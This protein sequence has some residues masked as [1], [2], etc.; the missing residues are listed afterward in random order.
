MQRRLWAF[1]VLV[2]LAASMPA[3][4]AEDEWDD[5][6]GRGMT[7]LK[8][9]KYS[10]AEKLF[11]S[12]RKEGEK[13]GARYG[14]YATSLLNLGQ[15]YDKM[16]KVAEA[17]KVY[18]EALAIY[19]K[20]Y[21]ASSPE[22]AKALQG[23]ADTYRH[24]NKYNEAVPLYQRALKIRDLTGATHPDTAET[25]NGLGESLRKQGKNFEAVPMFKRSLD[26]RKETFGS[27][28][29]KVAKSLDNLSATY[30]AMGKYDMA[31]PVYKDLLSARQANNGVEDPRVAQVLE[32][33]AYACSKT[34]KPKKADGYFKQ[35]LAIRE[36][37]AKADPAAL[38]TCLKRYA[39]FLKANDRKDE[40]AKME[41]RITG[42]GGTTAAA[43][44][45]TAVAG[46]AKA[47]PGKGTT[48]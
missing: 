32:D 34:D 44:K 19:E 5:Y 1:P 30:A 40:A 22:D 4:L 29:S 14:H 31:L 45:S 16:D 26:I 39:E 46:G 28:H 12:A 25:L 36:K 10:E 2:L 37:Q 43:G 27:T 38:N 48:K 13:S 33:L 47:A 3:A 8:D 23:L 42:A 9:G 41:A 20:S 7:A 6:N 17:E 11:L 35:A 18:K 21:G 24:H 15:V